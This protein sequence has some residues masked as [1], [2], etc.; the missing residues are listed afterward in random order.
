MR[1]AFLK[2]RGGVLVLQ[3]AALILIIAGW[4]FAFV[5]GVFP[6]T[7]VPGPVSVGAAFLDLLTQEVFWTAIGN[8]MRGA[9]QGLA[10]AIAVGVPVGMLTGR[11]WFA[12]K[13]LRFVNDFGRSFPAIALLPVLVL[14]I[15]A[16]N[17]MKAVVVFTAVVFPLII[18]AQHGAKRI[19]PAVEETVLAFRIPRSLALRKV[20]LP[21]AAPYIA[22]GIQLAATVSVL[23]A[24]GVE[25]LAAVPGV[26]RELTLAQQS[27]ASDYAFAYIFT[28][29]ILGFGVNAV[30][31]LIKDR[32][33]R[34]N[35]N[36]TGE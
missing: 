11:K 7:V 20:I 16:N 23:V 25:V 21:T 26:G 1:T 3:L 33:I 19:D 4:Q 15:G 32:L 35:A 22:T 28:A 29:G 10:V 30:V 17:S 36:D 14:V 9:L 27:S 13:S 2:T 24:L 34:W 18:Q 5:L 8:T 31:G 12:E 6:S